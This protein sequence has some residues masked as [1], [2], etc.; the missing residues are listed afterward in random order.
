MLDSSIMQVMLSNYADLLSHLLFD[1]GVRVSCGRICDV[2]VD[3][4][5]IMG[6]PYKKKIKRKL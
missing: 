4:T 2:L 5:E 6:E 3:M 1:D